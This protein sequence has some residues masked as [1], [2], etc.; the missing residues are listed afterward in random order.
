M[1]LNPNGTNTLARELLSIAVD[2][3]APWQDYRIECYQRCC[4][5][6]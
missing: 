4:F 6:L 2:P 3:G 5:R 1:A